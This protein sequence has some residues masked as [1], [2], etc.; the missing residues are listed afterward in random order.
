MTKEEKRR[1]ITKEELEAECAK[2]E[3]WR[4]MTEEEVRAWWEIHRPLML[5]EALVEFREAYLRRAKTGER[6]A[7]ARAIQALAGVLIYLEPPLNLS[8]GDPAYMWLID[9]IRHLEDLNVGVV[10]RVFRPDGGRKGL[11]TAEWLMRQ[12]IVSDVELF[13]AADMTYDAAAERVIRGHRLRG[14]SE[15]EVL[16]WCKEFQKGNVK[17][18]EAAYRYEDSMAA[19]R[20]ASLEERQKYVASTAARWAAEEAGEEENDHLTRAA[21]RRRFEATAGYPPE[22]GD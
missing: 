9:L 21:W 8:D 10:P 6:E 7:Y 22:E 13:H 12:E 3:T 14:V 17:N 15:K 5:Q 2:D 20:Q 18:Q 4:P 11:S 16:S 19:W 1:P